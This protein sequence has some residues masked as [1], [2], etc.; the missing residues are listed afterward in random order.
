[1]HNASGNIR[2]HESQF[3][4]ILRCLP[5]LFLF[6][7]L[8]RTSLLPLLLPGL[9]T[10]FPPSHTHPQFLHARMCAHTRTLPSLDLSVWSLLGRWASA[11][12]PATHHLCQSALLSHPVSRE[13]RLHDECFPV[14]SSS[15]FIQILILTNIYWTFIIDRV[16]WGHKSIAPLLQKYTGLV[17]NRKAS[18]TDQNVNYYCLCIYVLYGI[19][20][21]CMKVLITHCESQ[22]EAAMDFE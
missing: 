2:S 5:N 19:I 16:F 20:L 12:R 21:S 6:P 3:L 10:S 17:S 9:V 7:W 13:C 18:R 15:K 22:E 14:E 11:A 8:L 4:P 1:M